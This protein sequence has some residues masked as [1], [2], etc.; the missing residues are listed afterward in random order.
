MEINS[1]IS[2]NLVKTTY[3]EKYFDETYKRYYYYDPLT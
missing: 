1:K 2:G 3:Y